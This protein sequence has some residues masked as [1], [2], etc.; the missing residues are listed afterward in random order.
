MDIITYPGHKYMILLRMLQ[1]YY[2]I[3]EMAHCIT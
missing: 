2:Y 3:N 1:I